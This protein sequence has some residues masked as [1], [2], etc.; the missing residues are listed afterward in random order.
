MPRFMPLALFALALG[1][2]VWIYRGPGRPVI[3]GHVG[4]VA[5][6][7]LVYAL[8]AMVA[9]GALARPG[10]RAL[11]TMGIATAIECGQRIWTGTGL[12]GEIFL[13]G[14]FDRWDFAA[15]VAGTLIAVGYDVRWRVTRYRGGVARDPGGTCTELTARLR[16]GESR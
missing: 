6:T 16:R 10:W 12:A 15:Y 3:R 7:M 5:A 2:A 1:C 14:S 4:D 11:A 8:V 13:G 9:R